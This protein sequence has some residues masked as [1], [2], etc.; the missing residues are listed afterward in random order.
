MSEPTQGKRGGPRPGAGR[1][2]GPDGRSHRLSVRIPERILERF[3]AAARARGVTQ[4]RAVVEAFRIWIETGGP[5]GDPPE[6]F[7]PGDPPDDF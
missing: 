3:N 1:P 5:V 2:A 4:A 7:R 6:G